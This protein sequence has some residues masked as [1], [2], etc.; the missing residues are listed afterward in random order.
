MPRIQKSKVW[1]IKL[2]I[3]THSNLIK[4]DPR[5]DIKMF[6]FHKSN[7]SHITCTPAYNTALGMVHTLSTLSRYEQY[8]RSL[9]YLSSF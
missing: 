8:T 4:F 1:V 7:L 6:N 2:E 3:G 9:S 5:H